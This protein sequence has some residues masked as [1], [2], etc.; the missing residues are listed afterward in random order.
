M[1][2]KHLTAF[3]MAMIMAASAVGT[4]GCDKDPTEETKEKKVEVEVEEMTE[5]TTEESTEATTTAQAEDLSLEP[6][7]LI[8]NDASFKE[9]DLDGLWSD[10]TGSV[11]EI[12]T[13]SGYLRLLDGDIL[14]IDEITDDGIYVHQRSSY[15]Y[16]E[17][18]GGAVY[19]NIY[20]SSI[21]SMTVSSKYLDSCSTFRFPLY[22]SDGKMFYFDHEITPDDKK[23]DITSELCDGVFS[24]IGSEFEFKDDGSVKIKGLTISPDN[25]H[26]MFEALYMSTIIG[27]TLADPHIDG[28]ILFDH[29][30][31]MSD[32]ID[33]HIKVYG[34]YGDREFASGDNES[35]TFIDCTF[36]VDGKDKKLDGYVTEFD[37][38]HGNWV[39]Q[40]Y[41]DSNGSYKYDPEGE[42]EEYL[43]I[44]GG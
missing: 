35:N 4:A 43:R 36:E 33:C 32:V 34:D 13:E 27:L 3:A 2:R 14:V 9:A 28:D 6:M 22:L 40:D 37:E 30:S 5:E 19:R 15:D 42:Y 25:G 24:M 8:E 26:S 18:P 11:L 44:I 39:M 1:K 21:Q 17:M 20:M 41:Q 10:E 38:N 16:K 29:N 31:I 23:R 7:P 12:D